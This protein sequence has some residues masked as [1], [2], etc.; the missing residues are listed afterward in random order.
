MRF[1]IVWCWDSPGKVSTSDDAE[2]REAALDLS[3]AVFYWRGLDTKACCQRTPP[4]CSSLPVMDVMRLFNRS[5]AACQQESCKSMSE[6]PLRCRISLFW[7]V[8]ILAPE[9][10]TPVSGRPSHDY[11]LIMGLRSTPPCYF[12]SEV[13]G[14]LTFTSD[15][16]DNH[17]KAKG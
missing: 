16:V 6:I 5:L 1:E 10:G 8:Y 15:P 2:E 3:R 13:R 11:S 9:D 4:A 7:K 14:L 12:R 17:G